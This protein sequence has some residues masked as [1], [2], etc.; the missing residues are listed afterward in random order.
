MRSL[1]G[2]EWRR[3]VA[4]KLRRLR[5]HVSGTALT[6]FA[7]LTPV[8]VTSTGAIVD[9]GMFQR[10]R[11]R[12]QSRVDAAAV[13]S[14]REMSMAK[15]DQTRVAAVAEHYVT[16]TEPRAAVTTLVDM[17][18]LSVTVKAQKSFAPFMGKLFFNQESAVKASATARLNGTMPLCLLALDRKAA[19]TVHLEQ[20]ALMTAPSCMVYSNSKHASG[21]QAKDDAVL[22]A[23]LICSAGG[24]G[25]TTSAKFTPDPITDCPLLD[26]PL[27][28]R[29]T[30]SDTQ[31]RFQRT[32]V[33]GG[34]QTLQPGVYCDGLRITNGARVTFQKGTYI[35]KNGPFVVDGG[36]DISGTEVSF[37]LT[38]QAANLVFDT[39]STINIAAPKDGPMA[40]LLI[41][42]D[43][44]GASAPAIPPYPLPV[45][46]LGAVLG[47]VGGV[48]GVDSS[49]REHKILSDNARTLLGTIY[50][51]QGRLIVDATKPIAD[52]SAYTVLVVR[53]IDLHAGPNLFLNSDYSAS[54]VP[55]PKGLGPYGTKVMLTN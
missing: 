40:G 16:S 19:G 26:D 11:G 23:G 30:P 18:K 34:V 47:L 5:G 8:M 36:G 6:T 42:D 14:A 54:E 43:P 21:V 22:K 45:P 55:V 48:L 53:Q 9:Y 33:N 35:I 50:M 10:E 2:L 38:G 51:P 31:C 24:K 37:Y 32:V 12:L 44:S 20:A 41:Y 39:N 4:A 15:A 25:R 46:L 17:E 52:R 28:A 3:L 1:E 27:S 49:P 7:L 13:A 29:A